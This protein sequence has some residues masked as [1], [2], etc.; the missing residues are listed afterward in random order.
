MREQKQKAQV[1]SAERDELRKKI[2]DMNTFLR[3]Q[4][5]SI[6]EYNEQLVRRLIGKIAG[7]SSRGV[8]SNHAGS[9][10]FLPAGLSTMFYEYLM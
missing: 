5:T 10:A 1:E 2:D 8:C 3:E 6:T 4:P 7:I 9:L